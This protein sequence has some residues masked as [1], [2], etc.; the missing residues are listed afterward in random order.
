MKGSVRH[1][2]YLFFHS[3]E[4]GKM[5]QQLKSVHEPGAS[6]FMP[7]K[8]SKTSSK[9]KGERGNLSQCE[10]THC[11]FGLIRRDK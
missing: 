9:W 7:A 8:M 6:H 1:E 5:A 4:V 11:Y 2:K 3:E 10:W